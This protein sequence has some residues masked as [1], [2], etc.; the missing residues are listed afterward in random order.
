MSINKVGSVVEVSIRKH[1]LFYS[2]ARIQTSRATKG[3]YLNCPII[4][5]SLTI[6]ESGRYLI[7]GSFEWM[8]NS[9]ANYFWARLYDT[10]NTNYNNSGGSGVLAI[11]GSSSA[12]R[13]GYYRGY[14]S[15]VPEQLQTVE[16]ITASKTIKL[17]FR[18]MKSSILRIRNMII[19][20]I[21]LQDNV[22][23]GTVG[24]TTYYDD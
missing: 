11:T 22:G 4:V 1:Y 7:V 15:F 17:Q 14:N 21:K 9:I 5:P 18:E 12:Y 2:T 23:S 24:T 10:S 20:A 8:Y 16:E 13:W 6:N 3:N 19:Y